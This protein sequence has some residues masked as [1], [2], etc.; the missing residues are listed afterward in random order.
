QT[1]APAGG[2]PMMTCPTCRNQ[3]PAGMKFCRSCGATLQ[4]T[5]GAP[6]LAPG[7]GAPM[8]APAMPPPGPFATP[9]PVGP[10]ATPP[11][12]NTP[13]GSTITCPRCATAT[14]VG[15]AYCQQCGLHLNAIA[16]TDPGAVPAR[17]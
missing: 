12:P 10:N 6:A 3:N 13:S 8:V 1:P 5:P 16:P 7:V 9:P 17:I 14:P 11:R 2:L 15:F 4:T